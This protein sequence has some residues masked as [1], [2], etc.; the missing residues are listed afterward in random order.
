MLSLPDGDFDAYIFDCDGTLADSMPLYHRAWQAALRSQGA[1]FDF[2]WE[3]FVRRAGMSTARTVEALNLEFGSAL[4]ASLVEERQ[5]A[6]YLLLVEGVQPIP[7]VVE[8]A[9]R[10]RGRLPMSV[11]SGGTR[12]LVEKTLG[13]IGVRDLFAHVLVAGDV[14]SGKPEPDIFLLA[15]ERMGV[16]P[17]RCLVFED[18]ELGIVAAG[19]AGMRCVK[20]ELGSRR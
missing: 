2:G 10:A 17:S 14:Q 4:D 15:A 11:A 19:R 5:H 3:I 16:E 12:P 6:E 1:T 20:V 18:G 9:R 13:L 8:V 7:E